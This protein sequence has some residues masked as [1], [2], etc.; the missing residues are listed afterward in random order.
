[1]L[2]VEVLIWHNKDTNEY[3]CEEKLKII[4]SLILLFYNL[5]KTNDIIQLS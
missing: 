2:R 1:M 4:V 3:Q 5:F